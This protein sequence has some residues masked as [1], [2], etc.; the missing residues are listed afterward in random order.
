M[1]GQTN[2]PEQQQQQQRQQPPQQQ[3]QQQQQ[4]QLPQKRGPARSQTTDTKELYKF[5]SGLYYYP[6]KEIPKIMDWH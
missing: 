2:P 6:F 4:P 1:G 5:D 3:Q